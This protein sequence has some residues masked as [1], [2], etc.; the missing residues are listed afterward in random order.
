MTTFELVKLAL[1]ELYGEAKGEHGSASDAE[2]KKRMAYLT[3][4]Y[5]QL[6]ASS[7]KP[8]DYR[9]PA[10]RFAYVY[11]YVTA[12]ADYLVQVMTTLRSELGYSLFTTEDA[13]ISCIGGGPGS[14]IIA[15]LK[16]LDEAKDK[17][18]VKRV[19]CYLLDGEQAWADT[20]TELSL[21]LKPGDRP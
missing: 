15:A 19:T 5:N 17:E 20:W 3:G 14:D 1:D 16:Y 4:S 9:D 6:G 21:S 8:V 10:T 2:I 18:P 12:H 11:K 13:R 7:R